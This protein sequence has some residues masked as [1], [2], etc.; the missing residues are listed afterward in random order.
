MNVQKVLVFGMLPFCYLSEKKEDIL[1]NVK[2]DQCCLDPN[3][4]KESS[5]M[6]WGYE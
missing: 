2:G 6:K 3:V 4:P 1:K 5:G